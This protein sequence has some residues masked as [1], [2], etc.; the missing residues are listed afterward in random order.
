MNNR[1][2][3]IL[4]RV[5]PG[6]ALFFIA[7]SALSAPG[8][9]PV[10]PPE[11]RVSDQQFIH[12][13]QQQ[14]A[15]DAQFGAKAPDVRLAAPV[16]SSGKLTFPQETPCFEIRRVTVSGTESLPHWLPLQ[17]LAN[18]GT[19]QC[20][21]VQGINLLMANMQN[22]LISHGWV[23]TRVLAP[24]QD[25]TQG[26]LALTVIPG[27]VRQVRFT[28]DSDK[29]ATLYTAMP[30]REGNVLDLRDIEQGL[31]NL[32][33]LPT[34]E[35][36][37]ELVP[38]DEP[39]ESDIVI[40]R[41]QK[42][43]WR[44]N[45]WVDNTG[46]DSTGKNQGGLMFA[47]DNPSSL[48]DLFYVT[49]TRDL[50]FTNGKGSTNYSAHYSV[51]LGYWQ[52]ALTGSKY[53]Y[54]QTVA[55]LNGDARYKGR[56]ESLNAQLSNVLYRDAT[57]KTTLNYGVNFRQ[58][59]NYIQETEIGTQKR[60]TSTWKV[61]LDHRQYFGAAILDAGVSY[62]RGTRWFG[63]MPAWEEYRVR[64]SEDYATALSR[65]LQFSASLTVPFAAG[66]QHFQYQ[67]EYLRQLSGTPLTPQDQFSIGN[68]WSVRGFDGERTLSGDDGWTVRNTLTW[69]TPVP[70]QQL[71]L[72]M[73][74]GRVDGHNRDWLIGQTLAG[75]VVGL[76]GAYSPA[77]LSYD[78]SVGTP[79][80]K[81]DGFKTDNAVFNFNISWQY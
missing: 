8:D 32:Q 42:K 75:G 67:S 1:H 33:R 78:F 66:E 79:L 30:A 81:P 15:L 35:A 10:I 9:Q 38:G 16:I 47:L 21:G 34:V 4:S 52:L 37:M 13:Q 2:K 70:Q 56:S 51:P 26:T 36:S 57:A 59:R 71:Y 73:D 49:A 31:E 6:A 17:R 80:S 61:G 7:G 72:G 63:A 68:R 58:T 27:R 39:G 24:Q 60:R 20:L 50:L 44:L 41:K 25:L 19:G 23:T 64:D 54:V 14:D 55:M 48:S 12:Q 29:Y 45:A 69:F 65:I 76:K 77:G 46:T 18:E 43:M 28:D 5:L 53:D 11:K 62:Q 3:M 74:Y 40:T 22:R